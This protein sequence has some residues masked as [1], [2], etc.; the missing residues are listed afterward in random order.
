M[1]VRDGDDTLCHNSLG[2]QNKTLQRETQSFHRFQASPM[3]S[4]S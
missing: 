2:N 3:H 4:Q 1:K